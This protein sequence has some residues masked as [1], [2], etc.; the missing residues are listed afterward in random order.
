MCLAIALFCHGPSFEKQGYH[1]DP[2]SVAHIS[3]ARRADSFR[4]VG[5]SF[6]CLTHS[7]L[8]TPGG[9][10]EN[11]RV[12]DDRGNRTGCYVCVSLISLI[13]VYYYAFYV[14]L[15]SLREALD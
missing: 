8:Y 14:V 12:A 10:R 3:P 15:L 13:V 4:R 11:T 5:L 7:F 9:E 2:S 1:N 6:F